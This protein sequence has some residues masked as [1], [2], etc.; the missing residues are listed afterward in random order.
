MLRGG[1]LV[2]FPPKQSTVLGANALDPV[3]VAGIFAAK[4]RPT[5]NPLIVHIGGESMLSRVAAEWPPMAALLAAKYWP[6]PLTFVLPKT[7]EVPDIVTGGGP[8][9]AVRMPA[10]P[11]AL[12][13][14]QTAGVPLAA[15]SANLSNQLSPTRADHVF[16]GMNGRIDLILDG[17]P[18]ASGIESTVIDVSGERPRLLRPGPVSIGDLE[19]IVGPILRDAE[20][21]QGAMPSPGMMPRHYAPRTPIELFA[22]Q[23]AMCNR[24]VELGSTAPKTASV[25]IGNMKT[26][27]GTLVAMPTDS[28]GYAARL[29]AVLHDLD[30][31]GF[32]T[33]FDRNAAGHR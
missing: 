33:H 10:H 29:Y 4:G 19:R 17:G 21:V 9:V 11:V 32:A 8:T 22:D 23:L 24:I 31:R 26:P 20:M 25:V 12:R 27:A 5:N 6:G 18:T 15:P 7:E 1:G 3:A 28:A 14:I 16:A 13:L 2:A 30:A